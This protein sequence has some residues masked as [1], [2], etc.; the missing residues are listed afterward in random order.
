[1]SCLVAEGC[2]SFTLA[3]QCCDFQ[4]NQQN[5]IYFHYFLSRAQVLHFRNSKSFFM[6]IQNFYGKYFLEK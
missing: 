4:R 3:V 2:K 6:C 5:L 1:M